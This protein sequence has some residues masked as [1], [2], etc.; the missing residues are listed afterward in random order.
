MWLLLCSVS[1]F[2]ILTALDRSHEGFGMFAV[3]ALVFMTGATAANGKN[4]GAAAT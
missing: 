4:T 2:G 1:S 3:A